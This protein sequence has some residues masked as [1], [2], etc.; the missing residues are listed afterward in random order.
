SIM[1]GPSGIGIVFASSAAAA[2]GSGL[3]STGMSGSFPSGRL[4][5]RNASAGDQM[6][7]EARPAQGTKDA[8]DGRNVGRSC[9]QRVAVA[10]GAVS[11]VML[12][13]PSSYPGRWP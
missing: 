6:G 3:A 10:A 8:R 9:L 4:L 12:H 1:L 2:T 13:G 11:V 7:V 5:R